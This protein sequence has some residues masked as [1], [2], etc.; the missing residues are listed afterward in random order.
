M[1][2]EQQER[3]VRDMK[4]IQEQIAVICDNLKILAGSFSDLSKLF[5]ERTEG[6]N[7][8]LSFEEPADD[9]IIVEK[10]K[11]V[12]CNKGFV[13]LTNVGQHFGFNDRMMKMITDKMGIECVMRA[14]GINGKKRT[15]VSVDNMDKINEF[16]SKNTGIRPYKYHRYGK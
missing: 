13:L 5:K 9:E 12:R 3:F 1:T 11:R 16:A 2:T 10:Q 7:Y 6:T 4:D 8:V 15:F 14:E